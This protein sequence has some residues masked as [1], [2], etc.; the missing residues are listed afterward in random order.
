MK[1]YSKL[2][3]LFL[4]AVLVLSLAAC[5][6]DGGKSGGGKVTGIYLSPSKL[7]YQN[8]R[9]QY[10]YYLTTFTQQEITLMDDNTYCLVVSSATFSALELAESTN[11]AKG[12]ERTNSITKFYGAYTSQVNDLDDD[13]LDVTLSAPTRVVKSYDQ[14][15]WADTANWN[16][17][18]GKAV[19]PADID[20]DTGAPVA[21]PDAQPWTAQQFLDSVAFPETAVQVNVKT[22]SFDF[23]DAFWTEGYGA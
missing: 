22:S 14:S 12:N 18:M 21:N 20:P 4:A 1:K 5:G 23:T 6:G 3:V 17:T 7:S 19:T 8:M 13:L 10:N 15:Y 9:P 16:D 11:D 2:L